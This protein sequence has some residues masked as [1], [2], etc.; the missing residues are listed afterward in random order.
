MSSGHAAVAELFRVLLLRLICVFKRWWS[1]FFLYFLCVVIIAHPNILKGDG[2]MQ[3][4]LFLHPSP[5]PQIER[6]SFE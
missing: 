6:G 1:F 5:H 3:I 4:S 2:V